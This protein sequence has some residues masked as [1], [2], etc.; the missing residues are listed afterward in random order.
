MIDNLCPLAA[1]KSAETGCPVIV[2]GDMN[3]TPNRL[4]GG[5]PSSPQ[6][7]KSHGF[8]DTF[9][10]TRQR[11]NE[12]YATYSSSAAVVE[13]CRVEV[14]EN[15]SRR[16]DYIFTYPESRVTTTRYATVLNFAE[17]GTANQTPVS[18]A[19]GPPPGSS[20]AEFFL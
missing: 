16:I 19:F 14:G 1:R 3:C 13:E 12:N 8:L 18:I 7:Y 20:R 2:L 15:G 11:T 10:Q 17:D 9:T 6:V 5:I 4:I